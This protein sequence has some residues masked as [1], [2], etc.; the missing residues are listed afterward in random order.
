MFLYGIFG[1]IKIG[2]IQ[3]ILYNKEDFFIKQADKRVKNALD[4]VSLVRTQE[5]VKALEKVLFS[6]PQR[7]LHKL[8]RR[9]FVF[10]G[11]EHS[12]TEEEGYEVKDVEADLDKLVGFEIK[13]NRDI[14]LLRHN[15]RR[16]TLREIDQNPSAA[17][18]ETLEALREKNLEG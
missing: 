11:D 15:Y 7:V 9:N 3:K 18:L 17:V 12:A 5:R 4:I 8:N 13:R 1:W 2:F 10:D 14:D 6:E 16:A